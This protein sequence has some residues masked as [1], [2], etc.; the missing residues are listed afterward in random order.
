MTSYILRRLLA[1]IPVFFVVTV[2]VFLVIH[3]VPGD[4]IDNLMRAGSSPALREQIA[5]KYGLDKGLFEQYVMWMGRVL[6]LDFGTSIIQSRPVGALIAQ[7]LPDSLILGGFAFLFSTIAGISAGVIA[8]KYYGSRLDN[9][10]T[11]GILL[12]ST[13]PSFW[14]GLLLILVFAVWLG[15]VPVSGTRGWSS[16]ILPVIATGLGGV[17]L[18]ARVT[19]VSMIEIGRQDFVMLLRAKGVSE[20]R[21]RISHVLR[22]AMVPVIS[23]LGLRIGWILGGAITVEVVFARPGLGSL[24]IRALNQRDYPLVQ[25]CLLMLA[26]AVILGTILG[27]VAQAA[28][29]PRQREAAK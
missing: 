17:A 13:I 18:V 27:D 22:H 16:L 14:L 19:K 7:N 12:G 1:V 29:D 8:A 26:M 25:G 10:I 11:T 28:M 4:P 9:G 15:W 24:L 20:S 2:I 23:I 5:A 21:I 3:L 6:T